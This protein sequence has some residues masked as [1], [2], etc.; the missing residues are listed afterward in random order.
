MNKT[1]ES[2]AW[3]LA[4][5]DHPH[6]KKEDGYQAAKQELGASSELQEQFESAREF[7]ARHPELFAFRTLPADARERIL[8]RLKEESARQ[9]NAV[10]L[11]SPWT[12]RQ[13]FAW[14][15][16]LALFLA[17]LSVLSSM[18]IEYQSPQGREYRAT[19]ELAARTEALPD[20]HA[21]VRHALDEGSHF[22]HQS[23]DTVQ[24]VNWL[25]EHEGVAPPL[26]DSIARAPGMGCSILEGPRGKI[27]MICVKLNGQKVKLFITCSR[28][29]HAQ[30]RPLRSL[31]I[32]RYEALEWSDSNNFF[33]LIQSEPDAAMPEIML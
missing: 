26:P 28:G 25:Q 6:L 14:A 33:L 9:R 21:F 8:S 24:L 32:D 3:L 19:R 27:S 7:N 31:N 20:F 10:P 22:Q 5:E 18:F 29:L 23:S 12:Y 17:L 15:A 30:E 2:L 4:A 11:P 13:Q 16:V 1:N